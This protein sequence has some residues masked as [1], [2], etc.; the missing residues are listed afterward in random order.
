MIKT[1]F[2]VLALCYTMSAS[3]G[4]LSN[5]PILDHLNETNV[6]YLA[7]LQDGVLVVHIISG[8][9]DHIKIADLANSVDIRVK[10]V[11]YEHVLIEK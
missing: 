9:V 10:L 3:G 5:N 7:K 1:I 6:S 8:Q 4:H 11:D 2:T